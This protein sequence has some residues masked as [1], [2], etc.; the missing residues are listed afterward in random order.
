MARYGHLELKIDGP[1]AAYYEVCSQ[2]IVDTNV[3][4]ENLTAGIVAQIALHQLNNNPFSGAFNAI[5]YKIEEKRQWITE[6][7]FE[8]AAALISYTFH[9]PFE[10]ID[11]W[12]CDKFFERFIQAEYLMGT[13]FEPVDPKVLE[14]QQ[15]AAAQQQ[16]MPR[17]PM[18]PREIAFMKAKM[19]RQRA[20]A[21]EAATGQ[22]AVDVPIEPRQTTPV[23]PTEEFTWQR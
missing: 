17:R 14:E 12:D 16:Q 9:I 10:E 5:M 20:D 4:V 11:K 13:R 6:N 8:S 15:K 3:A 19:R 23:P 22:S 2:I 18:S 21:Q 7:W 1:M